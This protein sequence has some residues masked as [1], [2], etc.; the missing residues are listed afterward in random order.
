M[1]SAGLVFCRDGA[2]VA[3]LC[4]GNAAN[5]LGHYPLGY[6]WNGEAAVYNWQ[7]GLYPPVHQWSLVALVVTPTNGTLYLLNTNGIQSASLAHNHVLQ[8]FAGSTL[9]G[10]DA[11]APQ[12]RSFQGDIDEVGIFNYA[13]TAGQVLS[14]YGT[15]VG[16]TAFPPMI[17]SQP[18][19]Q[20]VFTNMSAQMSVTLTAGSSPP[21]YYQ[22]RAGS[23]ES[24]RI[25]PM[26]EALRVRAARR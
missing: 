24:I 17:A 11:Y 26:G 23:G 13:L 10:S 7:S 12:A 25:W 9:I 4:Y 18:A 14:L 3:G 1:G 2:T 16:V 20:V 6:N 19:G 5:G 22:W 21:L 15:G 8:A